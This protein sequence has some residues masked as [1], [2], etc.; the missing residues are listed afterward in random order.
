MPDVPT[1]EHQPGPAVSRRRF[2]GRGATAGV[3]IAGDALG[4][5]R[6]RVA[7]DPAAAATGRSATSSSPCR[8]TGRSTTTT[9]THPRCRPPVSA[10]ARATRNRTPPVAPTRRSSCSPRTSPIAPPLDCRASA[11]LTTARWMAS[12]APRS[13]TT[14]TETRRWS[15]TRRAELP[16]YHSLFGDSGLCANYFRAP[17]LGPDPAEPLL[18]H[19]RHVRRDDAERKWGYGV[20]DSS[21]W[22]IILACSRPAG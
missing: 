7:A 16:F 6:R 5:A 15:T 12:T 18:P 20:F 21:G 1:P 2:L 9:A 8:R 19:V 10:L 3:A 11:V 22:P 17:V 13:T 4:P 14:A